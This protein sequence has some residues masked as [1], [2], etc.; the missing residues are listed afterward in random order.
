LTV[1]DLCGEGVKFVLDLLVNLVV[2]LSVAL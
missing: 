1:S 2:H